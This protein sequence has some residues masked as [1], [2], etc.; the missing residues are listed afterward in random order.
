MEAAI[1]KGAELKIGKAEG[2]K[3][4]VDDSGLKCIQGAQHY[5]LLAQFWVFP[6]GGAAPPEKS[7]LLRY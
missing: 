3:T 2:V 5:T 4:F 1:S 6:G 7:T